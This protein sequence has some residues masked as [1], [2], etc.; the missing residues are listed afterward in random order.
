MRGDHIYVKRNVW[1]HHGIYLNDN[2]IIH[3]RKFRGVERT[4]LDGFSR[5]I[6]DYF[7][8]HHLGHGNIQNPVYI[9]TYLGS[10]HDAA[11]TEQWALRR[12]GQHLY[13]L[14]SYNCE[15]FASECK[16]GQ[17]QSI[18]AE[19]FDK[20]WAEDITEVTKDLPSAY[21]INTVMRQLPRHNLNYS[22]NMVS[23]GISTALGALG[24]G[25][26]VA[27]GAGT[28]GFLG[29]LSQVSVVVAG[30]TLTLPVIAAGVVGAGAVVG[31]VCIASKLFVHWHQRRP[32]Q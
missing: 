25:T 26:Q 5:S 19:V 12:L 11:E 20:I 32:R 2:N 13:S 15:H 28:G 31:I 1:T 29:G 23:Q 9:R 14:T 7:P 24:I 8:T 10:V 17:K 30:T 22:S 4:S 27:A 16:T 3:L 21:Q 18:Q 6:I